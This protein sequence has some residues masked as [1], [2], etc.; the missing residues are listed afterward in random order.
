MIE[1]K[2][3][4]AYIKGN[5]FR[6]ALGK[7]LEV[8]KAFVDGDEIEYLSSCY[9]WETASMPT[10][11]RLGEYRVKPPV[12]QT[13]DIPWKLIV[14]KWNYVAMDRDSRVFLYSTK[15]FLDKPYWIGT[16]F[17]G[18]PLVIDTSHVTDWKL[19]LT[20]RPKGV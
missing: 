1:Q 3:I 6:D 4:D 9:E 8:F 5:F 7:H 13:L 15:P 17:T 11:H 2:Y 20:E 10:F 18:Y 14:E 16:G 19:T 12:P